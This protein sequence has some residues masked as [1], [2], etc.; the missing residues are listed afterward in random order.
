MCIL[1]RVER[2]KL[3]ERCFYIEINVSLMKLYLGNIRKSMMQIGN[4]IRVAY[5]I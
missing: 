4:E 1:M 2:F 5:D 3:V